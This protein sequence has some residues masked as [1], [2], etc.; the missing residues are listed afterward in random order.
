MN[1]PRFNIY[2]CQSCGFEMGSVELDEGT[3]PFIMSCRKCG[4]EAH[5][6]FYRVGPLD[7][8]RLPILFEWFK[9]RWMR[10]FWYWLTNQD[11]WLHV[12]GGGLV[13]REV[14]RKPLGVPGSELK[15]KLQNRH[16]TP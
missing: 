2:T 1:I 12:R 6:A 15:K 8:M 14:Y 5:S 4:D 9:P 16:D 13:F 7:A 3:T 10:R 11:M